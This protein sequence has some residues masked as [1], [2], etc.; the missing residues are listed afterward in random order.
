MAVCLRSLGNAG[1]EL[2]GANR[3]IRVDAYFAHIARVGGAPVLNPD[4]DPPPDLLLVT[5][6]HPDHFLP[7]A[8]ALAYA[9]AA[10]AGRPFTVAGPRA[11]LA[12]LAGKLPPERLVTLEPREK[13]S[14]PD[15]AVYEDA[16]SGAR[17]TAFRTFHGPGGHNS[18][19]IEFSGVRVFHD[20]DSERQ[21]SYDAPRLAPLDAL[22]SCPWQGSGWEAFLERLAPKRWLLI[23]MTPEELSD[24]ARGAFL[25]P[26][27]TRPGQPPAAVGLWPGET[28]NL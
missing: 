15:A 19:L 8:V 16:A 13:S 6:G 7:S 25:P 5:H 12:A 10:A 26:L 28:V 21:Q 23:H 9:R 2:S 3:V 20:G 1:V 27:M 17:V 18:Y 24:H 11:A 14:P 22:C 4:R